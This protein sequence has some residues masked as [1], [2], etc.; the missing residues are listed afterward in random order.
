ME[1]ENKYE[2]GKIYKIVDNTNGDIYIGST[3]QTLNERLAG[4]KEK[5]KA[6]IN[7]NNGYNYCFKILENNDY[8]I[9]L[10]MD[11][12][13]NSKKEL[14]TKEREYI[15]NNL[16]IN[17]NIPTRTIKEWKEFNREKIDL[18][19]K[20]WYEKNRE[21][22]LEQQKIYHKNIQSKRRKQKITCECGAIVSKGYLLEH[23]KSQKHINYIN[24]L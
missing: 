18:Q 14:E 12:P 19:N 15:E 2:N 13:C 4:H 23:K 16:C 22:V 21:K 5:Y 3:I 10:L 1:C 9:E 11:Y 8:H 7:N 17:K 24:S 20:I 6:F